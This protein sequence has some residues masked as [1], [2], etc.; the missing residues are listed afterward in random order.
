MNT[1]AY[2]ALWAGMYILCAGLG[3]IPEPAGFG[4]F[5]LMVLSIGFFVP[6]SCLLRRASE[7]KNAMHILIVR[8][9]A[10]A[11]LVLTVVLIIGNFMSMLAPEAVGNILYTLLV[12]VS[13]PMICSQY[14]V[15]SL[16]FWACLM[17]WAQKLLKKK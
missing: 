4:K 15:I 13:A 17:I 10:V 6:P 1:T 11:S 5:C 8:N 14:W 9:L 12:I 7:E 2:Y 16:F 3:F